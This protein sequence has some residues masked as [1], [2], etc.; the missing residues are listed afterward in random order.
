MK[1]VIEEIIE[2]ANEETDT[3]NIHEASDDELKA[4]AQHLAENSPEIASSMTGRNLQ[5][6][7]TES[8]KK[9]VENRIF[10]FLKKLKAEGKIET[11]EDKDKVKKIT[12]NHLNEK[13][14]T[15]FNRNTTNTSNFDWV[16]E[17]INDRSRKANEVLDD[18]SIREYNTAIDEFVTNLDKKGVTDEIWNTMDAEIPESDNQILVEESLD[19]FLNKALKFFDENNIPTSRE[20]IKSVIRLFKKT[21]DLLEKNLPQIIWAYEKMENQ[22]PDFNNLRSEMGLNEYIMK[23]ESSKQ[24]KPLANGLK[25]DVRNSI[26]HTD[27]EIKPVESVIKFYD[28][29]ELVAEYEIE[30]YIEEVK[31]ILSLLISI[32]IYQARLVEIELK[33]ITKA[34]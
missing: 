6:K 21:N 16:S 31:E 33:K 14:S 1:E 17:E 25:Q 12:L 11:Q 10:E 34:D 2:L 28:S 8:R 7:V 20:E 29:G 5:G 32:W 27:R 30:E 24:L 23:L 26:G 9:D 3:G 18:T 22:N 13:L 15:I 19:I 4:A